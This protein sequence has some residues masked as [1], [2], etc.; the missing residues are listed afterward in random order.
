MPSLDDSGKVLIIGAGLGGLAL[1]Q[2][3]HNHGVPFELFERDESPSSRKQGWAVALVESIA[4]MKELLPEETT[5]HLNTTS[6]NHATGDNDELAFVNAVTGE[7]AGKIGGVPYGLPGSI[8]RAGREALRAYLWE[9]NNL[10]VT[11]GKHFLR[12]EEDENGVTAWFADGSSARGSLLVGADGLHSYVR[13]QLLADP[14][15]VPV[16][17]QYVPI[18]GELDLPQE[19]FEPLR[20]IA[21]AAVLT[22]G[23][24]LRQQI[25]MLSMEADG[26]KAR[27][28][29]A[30]MLRRDDPKTLADWVV[31]ASSQELYDFAV[32]NSQHLHPTMKN[33][34][35]YG[36]PKAM[37]SPQPRFQEFV[38]PDTLPSGRVTLLGDAAHAMIPLR[39]AGANTAILDACELGKLLIQAREESQ[40][41]MSIVEPFVAKMIPRGRQAVLASRAAGNADGD[42]PAAYLKKFQREKKQKNI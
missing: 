6:V 17:S 16:Q 39:G 19:Q 1:A 38:T 20:R 36:G 7:L 10:P 28:F 41:P 27:Y 8:I 11:V 37:I 12:Y 2:V 40:A 21:N 32:K 9:A 26:S 34:I 25:G 3:L 23:P 4:A 42:D 24:G 31:E 30:L 35:E 13:T 33:I 14:A 22:S 29:W 18:F 15:Q 5:K